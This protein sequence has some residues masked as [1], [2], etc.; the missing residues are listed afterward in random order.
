M[1]RRKKRENGESIKGGNREGL[2][3]GLLRW[4]VKG[5]KSIRKIRGEEGARIGGVWVSCSRQNKHGG[6]GFFTMAVGSGV[7]S[8]S[9]GVFR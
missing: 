2:L 9:D 5:K 4:P 3:S 8:C 7:G 6:S 1:K